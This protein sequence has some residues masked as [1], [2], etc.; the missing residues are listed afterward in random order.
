MVF[1]DGQS[2][3]NQDRHAHIEVVRLYERQELE[4]E[5][6]EGKEVHENEDPDGKYVHK[7]DGP[8]QKDVYENKDSEWKEVYA[9]G[10]PEG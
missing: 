8:D 6:P 3:C 4:D 10:C 5:V 2:F 9:N 1:P 7:N